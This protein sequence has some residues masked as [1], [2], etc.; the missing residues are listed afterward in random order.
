M[1]HTSTLALAVALALQ[2]CAESDTPAAPEAADPLGTESVAVVDSR[3]VPLSLLEEFSLAATQTEASAL[4]A[5][6]REQLVDQLVTLRILANAAEDGGLHMR[7][8]VAAELEL[9]RLQL[10]ARTLTEGHRDENRPTEAELRA[11]YEENLPRYLATQHKARHILVESREAA[12]SIIDDLDA[13]ADFAELAMEHSTGPTGP[14]GGDLGWFSADSMVPPFAEAVR[15]AEVGVHMPV[16][17]ETQF[18]WHVIL[19]E[20]V[21]EQQAPGL[22]AVRE[23]L[24]TLVERRK[25]DEYVRGLREGAEVETSATP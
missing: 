11:A 22:E 25:L 19:V 10:L 4:T 1:K 21:R 20:D 5:E 8:D 12:E 9:Q 16:P 24:V 14:R 17:V 7:R 18:G 23:E 2:G 15:S 13:G 3:P 6:Q